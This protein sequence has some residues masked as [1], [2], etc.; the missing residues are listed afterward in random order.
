MSRYR[1]P[2]KKPSASAVSNLFTCQRS[3]TTSISTSYQGIA[4]F[5]RGEQANPTTFDKIRHGFCQLA[6]PFNK[7]FESGVGNEDQT[8]EGWNR[9]TN[10][11]S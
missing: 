1:L 3:P 8:V 2:F 6:V 7:A 5:D 10:A 4:A 9:Q 11:K